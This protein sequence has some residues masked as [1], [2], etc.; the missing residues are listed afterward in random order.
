MEMRYVIL[1]ALQ[2]AFAHQS[3]ATW[4]TMDATWIPTTR[5]QFSLHFTNSLNQ[6]PEV[7]GGRVSC[8]QNSLNQE[9]R[10]KLFEK[11]K[12]NG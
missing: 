3:P 6:N 9:V 4:Q 8:D 12:D 7:P 2:I 10:Y 5:L 11:I 1:G